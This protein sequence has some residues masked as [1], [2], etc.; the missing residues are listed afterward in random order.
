LVRSLA[1]AHLSHTDLANPVDILRFPTLRKGDLPVLQAADPPFGGLLAVPP[2][3]LRRIFASPGPI[4][5]PEGDLPSY[6]RWER[7]LA[8]AGFREGDIVLN[9]LSYH[10]TPAGSMFDEAARNLGC[11]VIP[12]GIGN[13]E[14]QIE[15]AR[16]AGATAYVGLPSYLASLLDRARE[17]GKRLPLT[18]AFVLAEKLPESLRQSLEEQGV[19]VRQG[20]GTADTG[21]IAYECDEKKGLHLDPSVL[22]ELLDP[23]TG[24]PQ[25][26]GLPGEVVVTPLNPVYALLRFGTGDLSI[27]DPS[28]CPCGRRAPRLMGLLGRVDNATKVRGL[29]LHPEQVAEIFARF[30]AVTSFR[31]VVT[32]ERAVD[33][34]ALEVEAAEPLEAEVRERI[35]AR[36]KELLK[37]SATVVQVPAGTIPPR[38]PAIDDRRKWD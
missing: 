35:A 38:S 12:A 29:F 18:K 23:G 7:A 22:V 14:I 37:L 4:H 2:S 8:A 19:S 28:P 15:T 17:A 33:D 36:A 25:E 24:H 1:E 3:K 30:P 10:L 27:L 31:A 13:A 26:S 5:D 9:C 21:A 16:Q 34:L 11:V 20:Y 6:W 32:R